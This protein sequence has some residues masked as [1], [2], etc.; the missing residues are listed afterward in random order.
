MPQEYRNWLYTM[1]HSELEDYASGLGLDP[2]DYLSEE[3][4][5]D[6]IAEELEKA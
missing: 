1:D 5:I 4:L 6:A 3:A 2:D